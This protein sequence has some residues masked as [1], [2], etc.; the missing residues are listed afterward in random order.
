MLSHPL[1]ARRGNI[2]AATGMILAV[3]A[4][5]LLH[6]KDGQ[7]VGNIG[8]ILAAIVIGT[9]IGWVISRK[10]RMTAMP[11]L[12]SFF[13]GM[14][15]AA[16]AIISML[17]FP[18]ISNELVERTGMANGQVLIILLGLIIGTIS[19]AGSMIAFGKLDGWIGD[20]KNRFM[21]FVNLSILALLLGS[22]VFIMT[23]DVQSAS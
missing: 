1:T 3:V 7:P 5:I 10:V 23:R 16:A 13:N 6:E 12:V 19:W 18:L 4:T 17:E 22:I 8:L 9:V 20:M 2:L 21:I 15:G 14:G 11:Q